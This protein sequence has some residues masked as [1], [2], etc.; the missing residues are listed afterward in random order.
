MLF[1]NFL[2]SGQKSWCLWNALYPKKTPIITYRNI[3]S[4]WDPAM[5]R[6]TPH[7]NKEAYWLL[8]VNQ[9]PEQSSVRAL[10]LI[11]RWFI[12]LYL[13]FFSCV[14]MHRRRCISKDLFHT[15][16]SSIIQF[17][18]RRPI[19]L[20]WVLVSILVKCTQQILL[21]CSKFHQNSTTTRNIYSKMH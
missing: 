11:G 21:R 19:R 13:F 14:C 1:I 2:S 9:K 17:I 20:I 4:S 12:Y 8:K 18:Y 7:R 16:A 15:S 6:T 3:A 5:I 10:C